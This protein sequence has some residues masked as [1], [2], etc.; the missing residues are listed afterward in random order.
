MTDTPLRHVP[1][2]VLN[3]MVMATDSVATLEAWLEEEKSDAKRQFAM[4]RIYH[5]LS[6]VR[7]R[8]DMAEM[9]KL[10]KEK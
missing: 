10:A 8:R 1:V 2:H 6:L 9:D 5:R 3:K 7:R 4:K